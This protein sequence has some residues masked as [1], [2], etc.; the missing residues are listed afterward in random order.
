MTNLS[1][2][3]RLSRSKVLLNELQEARKRGGT[4]E[5]INILDRM[6]KGT[7]LLKFELEYTELREPTREFADL[8][9]KGKRIKTKSK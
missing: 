3:T 4:T 2:E 5:E 8:E 1:I 6:I 9:G 7:Q